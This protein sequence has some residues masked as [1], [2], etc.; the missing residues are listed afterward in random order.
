MLASLLI[1]LFAVQEPTPQ[2]PPAGADAAKPVAA[3]HADKPVPELDAAAARSALDAFSKAQKGATSMAQKSRA[4]EALA[5]GSHATLVAPL[6][7]LV[8]TEKSVVLKKRAAELLGNQPATAANPAI[9]KLLAKAKVTEQLPVC[10]ELVRGLARTDYQGTQWKAIEPLFEA[11]FAVERVPVQEAILD[12][13][14]KKLEAQALPL[15]LR[16]LDEPIP[17]DVDGAANPP[18]EYWEARWK[19]WSVWRSRVKDA[20]FAITGQRFSTA[21]EAKTWLDKNPLQKQKERDA[22]Q[23]DRAR[24]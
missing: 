18:K 14:T 5:E 23:E 1:S 2:T 9:V 22:K 16:H 12:L 4:L 11:D 7:K 6:V 20:V 13:A 10:A 21:A 8:E 17:S 24:K 15:L 19:S 3:V